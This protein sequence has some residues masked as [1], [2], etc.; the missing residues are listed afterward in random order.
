MWNGWF[1]A[2]I[3]PIG[4]AAVTGRS[5]GSGNALAVGA[6]LAFDPALVSSCLSGSETYLAPIWIGVAFVVSPAMAWVPFA[7]AVANHPGHLRCPLL[8]QGGL[9]P[10]RTTRLDRG[11]PVD[12]SSGIGHRW[13]W[14]SGV[15]CRGRVALQPG[16]KAASRSQRW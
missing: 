1:H 7:L 14:S 3:A 15:V 8:L 10:S 11:I 4:A 5:A 12:R 6:I 2:L 13:R 9:V 16:T